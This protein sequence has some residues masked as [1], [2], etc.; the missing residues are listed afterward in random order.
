MASTPAFYGNNP[1]KVLAGPRAGLR[2]LAPEEDLGRQF[3]T[4]L[5]DDQKKKGVLPEPAPKDIYTAAARK[6]QLDSMAGITWADLK[7][8]QR[9]A[10]K[11]LVSMYADRHRAEIASQDII[12]IDQAG[13]DKVVFAWQGGFEPG[14]P[15]YYRIKG[16]TFL[17]EYD[18]T[19]NNANHIHTV[20]RDIQNDFGDDVLGRHLTQD[21]PA[22]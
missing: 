20:W 5:S 2:T 13:W 11:A 22:K 7:V 15:H 14:Q 18:N 12:K 6:A 19:Q 3:V 21:H 9:E 10:L 4:W 1:A 17:V 8:E 16:P